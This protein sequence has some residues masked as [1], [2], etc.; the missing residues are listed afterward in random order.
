VV[1]L[2]GCQGW[3]QASAYEGYC[4][5]V[6]AGWVNGKRGVVVSRFQP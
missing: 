6:E 2:E 5:K 3:L 1:D 4:L